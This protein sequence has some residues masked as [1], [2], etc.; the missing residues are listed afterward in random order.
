MIKAILKSAFGGS[1]GQI[2]NFLAIPILARLYTPDDFAFWALCLAG[3]LLV[4]T[5][6]SFRYELAIM[7][8]TD[9]QEAADVFWLA[10]FIAGGMSLLG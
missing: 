9:E 6:A 8:P 2:I 5:I 1:G 7:I 10:L 3:M 4:G